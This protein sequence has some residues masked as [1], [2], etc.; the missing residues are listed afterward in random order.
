MFRLFRKLILFGI[1]LYGLT[2]LAV[3]G[4]AAWLPERPF[5][6]MNKTDVIVVLGAG[7]DADGTLHRSTRLRVERGVTLYKAGLAPRMHFTGGKGRID[8]PSAGERMAQMAIEMGVPIEAISFEELSQSTLQNALFSVPMLR[9]A[10]SIRLVTEGFHLPRSW[11]AFKWAGGYHIDL[12]FSERF[13]SQ[14]PSSRF[15]GTTMILREAAAVWFNLG[16][17]VVYEAAGLAGVSDDVRAAW[18]H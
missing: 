16:R 11:L 14:T 3:A 5:D 9:D 10:P 8:G 13:R 18:L 6:Q 1:I 17:M 2:V 12:A 4:F 15:P 7:M